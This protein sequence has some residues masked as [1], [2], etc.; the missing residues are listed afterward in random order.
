MEQ[1]QDSECHH[2]HTKQLSGAKTEGKG[3]IR[4]KGKENYVVVI[5]DGAPLAAPS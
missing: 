2:G 3:E 4:I 1:V 5:R